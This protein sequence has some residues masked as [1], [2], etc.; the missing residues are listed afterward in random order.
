MYRMLH[1]QR[2]QPLPQPTPPPSPPRN[3]LGWVDEEI[4]ELEA[5]VEA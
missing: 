3:K 5:Q 2:N 4:E 1:G